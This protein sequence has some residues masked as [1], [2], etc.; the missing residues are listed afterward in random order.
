MTFCVPLFLLA[1]GYLMR[2]KTISR[3]YYRGLIYI[4]CIY[5][6]TS[7]MFQLVAR[8]VVHEE[9]SLSAMLRQTLFLHGSWYA[10]YVEMYIGLFLII[11]FLN[12]IYNNLQTKRQKLLLCGTLVLLSIL[13]GF[14]WFYPNGQPWSFWL[15]IYPIAYYFAGMYLSEFNLQYLKRQKIVAVVGVLA[16]IVA[17]TLISAGKNNHIF[18]WWSGDWTN[19]LVFLYSVFLF[20]LLLDFNTSRVRPWVARIIS[21]VASVTLGTYLISAVFDRLFYEK[22]F[23]VEEPGLHFFFIVPMVI[24]LSIATSL[25]IDLVY[26]KLRINA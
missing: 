7:M 4:V 12:L 23:R 25:V 20:S 24:V 3:K 5:V 22:I 21:R 15:Q 11:P 8:F 2:H 19:P 17:V 6:V 1:T 16:V 10:W 18:P 14:L 26:R 9:V 13:P